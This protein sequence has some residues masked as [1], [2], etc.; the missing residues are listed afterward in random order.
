MKKLV[1]IIVAFIVVALGAV[2][3]PKLFH[4]CDDCQS[5]F[6]GTGYEPVA[7]AEWFTDENENYAICKKC[8]QIH[9]VVEIQAGADVD[10]FKKGLFD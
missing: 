9:H 8:A 10:D 4:T 7:I 1:C 3:V 2:F 5:F 6:V